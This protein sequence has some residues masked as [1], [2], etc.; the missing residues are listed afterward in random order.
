MVKDFIFDGIK[1]FELDNGTIKVRL[2]ELG[3]SVY[4]L[5][6]AG[7]NIVLN[8]DNAASYLE[9]G[10]CLGAI[11]GRYANRI[12]KARFELDGCEYLLDKNDGQN[13]LH[14][15]AQNMP[16]HKRIWKSRTVNESCV[17]FSIVLPDG[18]NGFPGDN[19]ICVSYS[20][21]GAKFCIEISGSS[22][23]KTAFGPTTHTYFNLAGTDNIMD[24]KVCINAD[25][26]V[27]PGKGLIPTGRLLPAEG[28][29]DFKAPRRIEGSYDHCFVLRGENAMTAEAGGIKMSIE[30]DFPGIQLYTG[31]FLDMG[32]K[33]NAGFAAEPEFFPDSPNHP[34]F[35]FEFLCPGEKMTK[36]IKYTFE[37]V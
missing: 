3:A 33:K 31:D 15:G 12:G 17:E 22:D 28:K 6:F 34:E 11:V 13:T 21:D 14:G 7:R 35:P 37:R 32:I 36:H 29:F 26:Y 9:S 19:E 27:E 23:K 30:T 20:I 16:L 10:S 8:Y 18:E 5:E 24:T 1:G 2:I 4:S 25:A